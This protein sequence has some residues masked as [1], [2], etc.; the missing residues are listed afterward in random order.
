MI[1]MM[2]RMMIM[3]IMRMRMAMMRIMIKAIMILIITCSDDTSDHVD[4]SMPLKHLS[5]ASLTI[6]H[7]TCWPLL[8]WE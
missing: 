1:V 4:N 3:M 6:S 2:V 5:A 7:K 8:V